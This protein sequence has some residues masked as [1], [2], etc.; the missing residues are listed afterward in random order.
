VQLRGMAV[1]PD[2]QGHGY[3]AVLLTAGIE[4][5]VT[6]GATELWANAR[7]TALDFYRRHGFEV[8]GEGFVTRDT[9]LPHHRIRLLPLPP[10]DD[11][12]DG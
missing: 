12:Q 8:V 7:D 2:E 3:G 1:A 10:L 6:T 11:T 5:F 9:G 4:R